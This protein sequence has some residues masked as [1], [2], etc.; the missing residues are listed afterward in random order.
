MGVIKVRFNPFDQR[1]IADA[2]RRL[3]EIR[4]N[5]TKCSNNVLDQLAD[6]GARYAKGSVTAYRAYDTGYLHDSIHPEFTTA[7]KRVSKVVADAWYAAYVEYGTGIVG[8]GLK[9]GGS[10]HPTA[11]MDGWD[12]DVNNHGEDGWWYFDFTRSKWQWTAGQP[13]KPFMYDTKLYLEKEAE[14]VYAN[15][16]A[17]L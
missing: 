3:Y 11:G 9:E 4:D 14:D 16:F 12:Y 17:G 13:A 15:V 6:M 10:E 1:S 2:V 8:A 5:I 7:D